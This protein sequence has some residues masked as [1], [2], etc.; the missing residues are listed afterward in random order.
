MSVGKMCVREVAVAERSTTVREAA[1]LMR[2]FHVGNL[3]IVDGKGSRGRPVG[4]VTD[5]DI[6][7]SV[8]ATGLDPAV[9][10]VGDLA[11]NPLISCK[12]DEGVFEC[13]QEMRRHGVRRMPVVDR[14]GALV[15]IV[16]VDDLVQLLAEEMGELGKLITRE[17][18]REA[19]A[20]Q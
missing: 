9:F 17:Q 11:M 7:L 8:V 20:K 5:R 4:I 3:V 15:G 18:A 19:L 2:R 16:A 13:V 14:E 1:Q 10:T 6:V 12:E